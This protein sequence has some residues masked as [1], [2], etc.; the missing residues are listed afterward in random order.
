[1][2]L[3]PIYARNT[4]EPVAYAK[5]DDEDFERFGHLRWNLNH[6]C[7][8]VYRAGGGNH[9]VLLAREIVG[10]RSG[11]R[12]VALDKDQLN[13]QSGNL[14][15]TTQSNVMGTKRL[16][17]NN[18]SG[19]KGVSWSRAV[20]RWRADI[21]I[22]GRARFLGYHDDIASAADAYRKA[23]EKAFGCFANDGT[24]TFPTPPP[25]GPLKGYPKGVTEPN[26]GRYQAC[27]T[28]AGRKRHLGC[29]DTPEEAHQAYLAAKAA[30]RNPPAAPEQS[31]PG[32]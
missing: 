27:V 15:K 12:V 21:K 5:V 28:V 29:F 30:L 23:A 25:A 19:V 9:A 8:R 32:A 13:L 18:T 20:G 7:G 22:N 24:R 17:R 16:G 14:R 6:Q 4:A 3:I 2:K 11:E 10:A 31:A 26:P 1:M